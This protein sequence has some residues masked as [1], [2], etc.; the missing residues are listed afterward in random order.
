MIKKKQKEYSAF[1]PS[2][3]EHP[4]GTTTLISF[5]P[6]MRVFTFDVMIPEDSLETFVLGLDELIAKVT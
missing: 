5:S 1:T 3:I 4:D 2:H 6:N